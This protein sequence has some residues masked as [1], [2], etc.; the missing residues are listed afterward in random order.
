MVSWRRWG[1]VVA[2]V[3]VLVALPPAVGAL[4]ARQSTVSAG[5][6]L[7][8][9]QASGRAGYS[10]YAEAV[11]GLRLPLTQQFSALTDLFG[12]RTR[13]RVW[14]RGERDW[15]VDAV[16]ATGERGVH[17]DPSGSWSW[18]YESNRATLSDEP[19]VRLPRAADLDPAQLG[20]R[21]LSEAEPAEVT[22]L[23]AR[24]IAGLDAPG[25]RL[26][27]DD[28]RTT[29]SR[30]DV[31]VDPGTGLPVQ[32]EVYGAG[33][34]RAA[35]QSGFLDFTPRSPDP[36]TT[37]F[38]PPPGARLLV[39][40]TGDLAA[41]INQFAQV[42]PPAE[43][44]GYPLRR[45][46]EGL[47]AIGT[48]GH[49]VTVLAAVPLLDRLSRPLRDALRRTPG[50]SSDA[51]GTLLTVGPLSLLLSTATVDGRLWLVTGTVTAD[52]L[53]RAAAELAAPPQAPQ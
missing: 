30:V 12:G 48:Y 53:R 25:L 6:L 24:R 16:D 10:G 1:A 7:A 35:L 17:R 39:E 8:D 28:P 44:A 51:D 13:L 40:Q 31:W 33:Q 52:T 43:L 45:R 20:R 21:L 2:G 15:R 27:P 34:S 38:D 36:D 50:A 14:W 4:S 22:R 49:G 23:P 37:A 18:D 11:G 5:T 47:G 26:H 29:I 19:P 9:V 46:V 32:V 42:R 3:A 41:R